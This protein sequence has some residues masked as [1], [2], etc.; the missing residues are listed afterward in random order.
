MMW[1]GSY[2]NEPVPADEAKG[3]PLQPSG[4]RQSGIIRRCWEE[5]CYSR[6][7]RPED[8]YYL[9]PGQVVRMQTG[10][11]ARV[12]VRTSPKEIWHNFEF[13]EPGTLE[14]PLL[15]GEG[16]CRTNAELVDEAT[17][18]ER[19]RY[20]TRRRTQATTITLALFAVAAGLF[21]YVAPG[22][23][24][25]FDLAFFIVCPFFVLPLTLSWVRKRAFDKAVEDF[26]AR[27]TRSPQMVR[28][29]R[30]HVIELD[31]KL[32]GI[33]KI[34]ARIGAAT[35]TEAVAEDPAIVEIR[36]AMRRNRENQEQ[37]DTRLLAFATETLDTLG[38]RLCDA[39]ELAR[40]DGVRSTYL[41][42]VQRVD[43]AAQRQTR[44]FVAA[45]ADDIVASLNALNNQLASHGLPART[46]PGT[47][48]INDGDAA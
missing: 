5:G 19:D 33:H 27:E 14:G 7:P 43:E 6:C 28:D 31:A 40:L 26:R 13:S 29:C 3:I 34:M 44:E 30:D 20:G 1:D 2:S 23:F 21:L 39:P 35:A 32:D 48:A 41:D 24:N 25:L 4:T 37:A 11:G 18:R 42:V 12:L 16:D 36:S 9:P 8:V 45:E 46:S 17:T 10:T 15:W 47:T 22:S 38:S